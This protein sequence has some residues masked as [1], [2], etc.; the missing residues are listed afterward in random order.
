MNA[1]TVARKNKQC[2]G[3]FFVCAQRKKARHCKF[4][5]QQ[6][7]GRHLTRIHLFFFSFHFMHFPMLS[8]ALISDIY[9]PE[10]RA[11]AATSKQNR[12]DADNGFPWTNSH[13]FELSHGS[14]NSTKHFNY[15]R[16]RITN[17][18]CLRCRIGWPVGELGLVVER[19]RRGL[20][21][22]TVAIRLQR[23]WAVEWA[24]CAAT[25]TAA[26]LGWHNYIGRTDHVRSMYMG[27]TW[28]KSLQS[29]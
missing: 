26:F 15:Q 13:K 25:A 11:S 10:S 6:I 17:D 29:G 5:P 23:K 16:T 8:H 28:S 4:M 21:L 9:W 7:I 22:F 24:V 14:Q 20:I 27:I 3:I 19:H 2:T 12:N 1:R 18:Q